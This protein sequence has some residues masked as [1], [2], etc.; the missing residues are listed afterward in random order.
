MVMR[1]DRRVSDTSPMNSA[2]PPVAWPPF[3]PAVAA[4]PP[5]NTAGR[6]LGI[7]SLILGIL[8]ALGSAVPVANIASIALGTA[9]TGLG[10]AALFHLASRRGFA[11]AGTITSVLALVASVALAVLYSGVVA[12]TTSAMFGGFGS[13]GGYPQE[14]AEE[15]LT[16][17]DDELA[18]A[19][20]FT[21]PLPLGETLVVTRDGQPRWEITLESA[22]YDA[23]EEVQAANPDLDTS[24]DLLPDMQYAYVTA[25]ITNVG[26][27][28][29]SVF[30]EL[31]VAFSEDDEVFYSPG[32]VAAVPPGTDLSQVADLS[33]GE[34]VEGAFLIA[35]PV[36]AESS[37]RWAV[38]SMWSDFL[39]L[40]AE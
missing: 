29:A 10:V 24:S 20:G 40:A 14:Y 7:G 5:V 8:A 28:T 31:Y 17:A 33:A 27:E 13:I 21:E 18:G 9:G 25:E 32:E 4:R 3:E 34:S 19:G 38:A 26:D 35:V 1:E 6:A 11:L 22:T 16:P 23:L 12:Q 2:L 37:G 36:D 39:Y 15:T 30:D